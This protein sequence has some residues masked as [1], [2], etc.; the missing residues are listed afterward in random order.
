MTQSVFMEKYPIYSLTL[1]KNETELKN[2]DEIIE[3]FKEKIENHKIAKYIGIFDHYGHTSALE[4]EINSEIKDAKNIIFC[5]GAK[6]PSSKVLAVRPRSIGVSE[7]EEKFEID[8]MEAPNDQ[9]T[10]V[11]QMW[12]KSLLKAS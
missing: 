5:F 6:L 10:D 8:F 1:N 11:M 2:V 3:Y 9:L 7:F 12:A 4:G